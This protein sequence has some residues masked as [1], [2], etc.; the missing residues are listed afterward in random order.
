MRLYAGG[1]YLLVYRSFG[2]RRLLSRT[3]EPAY[4]SPHHRHR[5]S[6]DFLRTPPDQTD[7]T[8]IFP[9][10]CFKIVMSYGTFVSAVV[11]ELV[12]VSEHTLSAIYGIISAQIVYDVTLYM[13]L[14]R[15]QHHIRCLTHPSTIKT[16]GINLRSMSLMGSRQQ[17]SYYCVS[18]TPMGCSIRKLELQQHT[19]DRSSLTTAMDS[20]RR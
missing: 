9:P 3:I 4:Y 18:F 5:L 8:G 13:S 6:A 12:S 15:N 16:A 10:T 2:R 17:K 1:R 7:A 19:R 20:L 14:L 11:L